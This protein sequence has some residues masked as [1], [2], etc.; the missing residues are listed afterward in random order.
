[1][2]R[3]LVIYDSWTGHT[4]AA[5]E[6]IADGAKRKGVTVDCKKIDSVSVTDLIGAN[7]ILIGCPTHALRLTFPM[8]LFLAKP[9]VKTA[10]KKKKVAIFT[11]CIAIPGALMGLRIRMRLCGADIIGELAIKSGLIK[12]AVDDFDETINCKEFGKNMAKT[13]I[14]NGQTEN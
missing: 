11:S 4:K 13:V 9:K 8:R 2:A 7:D 5:A 3:L 12:E 10:L 6:L 1:M 14:L